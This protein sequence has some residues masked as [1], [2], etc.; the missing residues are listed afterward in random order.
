MRKL[1]PFKSPACAG[2]STF[3]QLFNFRKPIN[4]KGVTMGSR[5]KLLE[6]VKQHLC[7]CSAGLKLTPDMEAFLEMPM[8]ELY[9]SLPVH[10]DD[11]SIKVFKGFRV[12]Y[13]EALGPTKGGVRF[14][15]E[16]T[17][18]T[19]RAL[20]AL[21]TWK[22]ALH[23]LPLGGAKGGVVCNPKELSHREIERLSRAYIRGIYQIIGPDRDIPAPDVYTNP[24]V[25]AWMMD[26][27][28]KLAGKNVF[29]SITGKPT[30][31]GGSAGRY[32]ATARGGLYTIREAA[33]KLGISLK[34]SRVAVQ[35]FG[36]VGY[37][38]AYLAK[39]LFGCKI[40]AVGDSKGAIFST[41]GL[42]PEDVSGHKH[43]TGSVLGYPGAENITNEE[44]L[45]LDVEILIPAALENVITEEN[46]GRVKA[47][48]LAEMANG[49]TTTEAEEI[50]NSNGVHL[51]PDILCNGGGVIVSYFEMVQNQSNV[52]WE[53]EEIE[54]RLERK[55]KEAYLSVYSF[56]AKNSVDMRQAA[57][58]LAVGRVVEA[59]QL[60]GWI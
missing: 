30:S 57:Y 14:H 27:Y 51:I 36:N 38:A 56:A 9:V 39:K 54:N 60:R 50:L 4:L 41:G 12:Q 42:D 48:I 25:M 17:I 32:D 47:R 44:L 59:M 19:I 28:S 11:G 53:E 43:S 1:L 49:P 21:M 58:T 7:T 26:E 45:E 5:S 55:M 18:E 29:G 46:A 34:D 8:R 52:Q 24:Q 37:H 20:A 6:D 31:L 33:E 15:P 10:M 2:E 13:N 16:E 40:V 3:Q 23:R 35:G 22:C